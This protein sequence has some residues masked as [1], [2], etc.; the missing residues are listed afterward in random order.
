MNKESGRDKLHEEILIYHRLKE[1]WGLGPIQ[2]RMTKCDF[3]SPFNCPG[4]VSPNWM[5][6]TMR[7]H[8]LI[9]GYRGQYETFLGHTFEEAFRRMT[10]VKSSL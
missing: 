3:N 8:T 9:V 7:R 4:R 6:N 10:Y 2:I 1:V 5:I